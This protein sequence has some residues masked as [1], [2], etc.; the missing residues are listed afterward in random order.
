MTTELNPVAR[1]HWSLY[2]DCPECV[3][4]FD[5]AEK[6][7]DNDYQISSK[8]FHNKWHLLRGHEVTC[9]YCNHRFSLGGVE[10]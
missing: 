2:V 10:Y 5:L 9:P 4:P 7:A 3:G 8:I 1:L 6:D